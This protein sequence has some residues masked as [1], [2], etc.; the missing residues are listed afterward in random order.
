L[1]PGQ[2]AEAP[3]EVKER[4]PPRST[5]ESLPPVAIEKLLTMA[6]IEENVLECSKTEVGV[7]D[8]KVGI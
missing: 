4:Q 8:R 6:T 1:P 7:A 5:A 2:Q 3:I